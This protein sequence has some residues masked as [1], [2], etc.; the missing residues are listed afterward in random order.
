[1]LCFFSSDPFDDEYCYKTGSVPNC[2]DVELTV[3]MAG[4]VVYVIK[5]TFYFNALKKELYI[6]LVFSL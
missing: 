1:M 2:I 6:T 4:V 3:D 5:S